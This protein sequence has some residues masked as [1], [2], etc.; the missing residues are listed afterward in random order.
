MN[1]KRDQLYDNL[2]GSGKVGEAEIGNREEFK[3]AISDEAKTRQFYN[4]IINSGL[5]SEDEIGNEDEFYNSI[6]G[7]FSSAAGPGSTKQPM[8]DAMAK[9]NA[10]GYKPT[11]ED[12]AAFQSTINGANKTVSGSLQSFDKKA[13]NLKKRQ[14]LNVPKEVK[15]G[16]GNNLVEGEQHLNPE[17][18]QLEKTYITASGN[19]YGNKMLA[20]EEQRQIDQSIRDEKY[21]ESLPG[22]IDDAEAEGERLDA[23]IAKLREG[24]H[25][26][27]M[28]AMYGG[29]TDKDADTDRRLSTL[30]AAKRK[31]D[32][33][34]K[35]L[36]A[37]RDDDGGTQ[38]WRGFYDAIT[39][40]DVYS[41][42]V[43][44]LS[45]A[46]QM[47]KLKN[48]IDNAREQGV[49]PEFTDE[50]KTL[51]QSIENSERAQQI[52]G[53][54]RGSMYNFGSGFAQSLPF[55]FEI[56]ATGGMSGLSNVGF[57]AGKK[58]ATKIATAAVEKA[59]IRNLGKGGKWIAD[60]AVKGSGA[61][62]GIT[63]GG[64]IMANTT[65]A[66][67]T[68]ADIIDRFVGNMTRDENG[69]LQFEDGVSVGEAIAKG[70]LAQAFEYG[71]ELVGDKYIEKYMPIIGEAAMRTIRK[72]GP[73]KA[74]PF[75]EALLT[76][77]LTQ[78]IGKLTKSRYF[79]KGEKALNYAG[80][81][82]WFA[83]GMEEEAN[84]ILNAI[85][86]GDVTWNKTDANKSAVFDTK[87]QLELWE[88]T[89]LTSAL[90][91]A[92]QTIQ[93]TGKAAGYYGYKHATDAA[94][95]NAASIF[96][97]NNWQMIKEEIDKCTNE[98][99][100]SL[101]ET[102]IKGGMT[103][104]QKE[105]TMYYADNLLK[106][107]GYNAALA[108]DGFGKKDD[109]DELID[110][111]LEKGYQQGHQ[112]EMPDDQKAVVD[113]AKKAEENLRQYG[114][115]FAIL[116]TSG[117]DHPGNTLRY[118]MEH[119]DDFTDEQIAAAT[120]YY[121]KQ[122]ASDAMMDAAIDD[123]DLKIRQNTANI[124]SNSHTDSNQVITAVNGDNTYY[125]IGGEVATDEETGLP[126]IIGTGGAV[127]VKD[128]QTGEISVMAPQQLMPVSAVN[129][130][131]LVAQSEQ[132]LNQQLTQQVE[133]NIDYGSP[134]NEVFQ[135]GDL[136]TL[137]DREGNTI[138]GQISQLPNTMDG[139]FQ[140]TTSDNKNH[141]YTLDELNLMIVSHNGQQ[142]QR[143]N[144]GNEQILAESEQNQADLEQNPTQ[145]AQNAGNYSQNQPQN[146][147]EVSDNTLG[148]NE[149]T[150][151]E[152]AVTPEESPQ[153]AAARIPLNEKGEPDYLHAQPQDSYDALVE[154]LGEE[155]A[156]TIIESE[157]GDAQKR[158]ARLQKKAPQG[159]TIEEKKRSLSER[160]AAMEAEQSAIDYW[161]SVLE[162]PKTRKAEAERKAEEERRRAEE[163]RRAMMQTPD[164]RQQLLSEARN[165]QE[166]TQVAKEIYGEYFNENIGEPDTAEELV[167]LLLPYGKLNWEGYQR[168]TSHV[169][170]LQEELGSGHTR[171]LSKSR[172]TS[173]FNSYLARKGEGESL[174][175]IV[176]Q[177]YTSDANI[178][179][180]E[181]RFS[182]EEIKDAAI[183]MLLE[184]EKPT[185]I[186]DY[187]I[188]SRIDAAERTLRAE[189]EAEA[190]EWA[191][192]Y[193]LTSEEREQF[194]A[195]LEMPP[196]EPEIEVINQI[197]AEY[198]QDTNGEGV[199]RGNTDESTV[200]ESEGSKVDVPGQS[201][202]EE[203][204][205]N[206]EQQ[207]AGRTE[208][209]SEGETLPGNDVA[210]GT[211]KLQPVGIGDFG[212]I[213]DQFKGKAKEAI[214][215]LI[216]KKEGEAIG[217]L[218]HKDVGEIDLV[219]GEEGTG[220]SDGYGL[221]KLV[222][223][224]PE[225]LDNLQGILDEMTVTSRTDNRVNLES[226]KYKAAVRLTWNEES[227]T[228]LLTVFEKKPSATDKTTDT[229]GNQNDSRSDTA[230][231]R[232]E[233]ISEGKDTNNIP[234]N[235]ENLGK[236]SS[237][238]VIA[239]EEAKVD[240]NP[241]EA[242]KEAGNYQMG[243][244]K[245]DGMD[246]SIENPKGSV[247]RGTD[248]NGHQWEQEMHNSYGYIRG[249]EAV[250]GDHIDVFLSDDPASGKV[251]VVDQVNPETGEF[252]EP[253]VMLGF[254]DA[255]E[256][257]KA[258]LSNYEE[259]WKGLGN[260]TGVSREAFKEWIESSH[261]KT[262]PF[263]DYAL[264][265]REQARQAK[266]NIL[267]ALGELQDN[268]KQY[269]DNKPEAYELGV[270]FAMTL[271]KGTTSKEALQL[272]S[273]ALDA[274]KAKGGL[275]ALPFFDGV[276]ETIK[277]KPDEGD[278]T[279]NSAE[280][281]SN[282]INEGA[283]SEDND[284][285]L[286]K[287]WESLPTNDIENEK[288]G[289]H[290]KGLK[291][292]LDENYKE[293]IKALTGNGS[294]I[295][296]SISLKRARTALRR[297]LDGRE[298]RYREWQEKYNIDKEGRIS[299]EDLSRLFHDHNQS[300]I[301]GK[302]FEKV[303][304][305]A[306]PL[307]LDIFFDDNLDAGGASNYNGRVRY[308][309]GLLTSSGYNWQDICRTILHELIHSVTQST[310][311]AYKRGGEYA[312]NLTEGQRKAA[313][314]IID[315]FGE[316]KKWADNNG[317]GETYGFRTPHEM[318]AEMASLNFRDILKAI[319]TKERKSIW[320]ILKDAMHGIFSLTK[321]ADA[322]KR[323][324]K[325]LD[326]L[327]ENF[328]MDTYEAMRGYE[329]VENWSQPKETERTLMGVHNI[330]EEKLKKAL[331]QGGLANPSMA[332][333]DTKNY[334]HTDYGE[335]SLIPRSS[336]IDSRTGR[337]AGT[338]SGDAWTPT[339][340]NVER[341]L[342]KK[343][344]KHRLQIAKD[345]ADGD[346][347]M[348]RHLAGVIND[349]VEGNG[350]RMHFLFLKQKGLNPEVRPERTTH[351]H[352]E[353]EEIQ[354]IF[355]E[356]TSTLPSNGITKEQN[357]ALL[358]LMTKGYEEQ[359]RKQAEMIKDE[360]KREAAAKL[361]LERKLNDLVDEN[362][363]VWFAKGD[364]FVYENWRDEQRRKNPKPDW[365]GTD[366]DASYRVAKEG[367][368]EEYEKWKEDLL[369]DE[370]IDEKLFAGWTADGRKRYVA[371]TVQNASRLMNKE[372]DTNSYGNGGVNASK[373]GLLKKLK[374]LSDIRKY[375]HLL[376]SEDQIKEQAQQ[377]S[378]EWFDII[379]QVSDMQKVDSNPFINVDIAEA[380]L[381]EA[382]T[383]R[384]PIGYLN[385][386]YRYSI[387]R[388]SDLVSD[389][390][391]FIEKAKEMPVKYFETKFKRP[392]GIDEFAIAVVPTTTS[393]EVIEALK[394][395]GLDV[396]TYERGSIGDA[397][398]EAR[399]KAT[400]DAVKE[401][402]DILFQKA[403]AAPGTPA[404][405]ER[406]LRDA[407][408][409]HL[410]SA[411]ID[412]VTDLEEGQR[413][414]LEKR[415]VK[416]S[417]KPAG[418]V[419]EDINGNPIRQHKVYHGSGAEFDAFDHSHMGEGE[420]YQTFGYGTYVTDVSD[421]AEGY[422]EKGARKKYNR[423]NQGYGGKEVLYKGKKIDLQTV[424]PLKM[425]YDM[426]N[427]EG[428]VNKAIRTSE[429]LKGYA[430]DPEMQQKWQDVIDI[431]KDS[432][433]S[434]F[435]AR[436]ADLSGQRYV[437]EVEI[438]DDNGEN[439]LDYDSKPTEK[440]LHNIVGK[441]LE[442]GLTEDPVKEM[443]IAERLRNAETIGNII[444]ILHQN[445]GG[446]STAK[447]LHDAGY[448][449]TKYST[450][451]MAG[452]NRKGKKNYV[453]Y[454]ESDAKITDVTKFFRTSDG[455]A[456]GYT[457]NGK[458]YI[459]PS[460]ATAETPVHEYT[461]LWAEAVRQNDPKT[462][463][464]IV[465]VLKKD[466]AVR[467]FWNKVAA[468][469][470]E[471]T[472]DNDIAEE[473]LAQYS[474][475]RGSEKLR[476]EADDIAKENGGIFGKAQAVEAL[477][478]MRNILN[479]F[480]KA[481]SDMMGWQYTR[482]EEVAD[483]V[484]SDL[485]NGVKPETEGRTTV[486]EQRVDKQRP[487]LNTPSQEVNEYNKRLE[488]PDD[489]SWAKA[490]YMVPV[491]RT[492]R[493]YVGGLFR[494]AWQDSMITLKRGQ[495][496]IVRASGKPLQ[497][498]EDA[499]TLENLS[500]GIAKNEYEWF[501]DNLYKP[502]L[503]SFL[504]LKKAMNATDEAVHRYMFAKHGL[505][506]NVVMAF[507]DAVKR[508]VQAAERDY[509]TRKKAYDDAE[510]RIRQ[511]E[512]NV[513]DL[514]RLGFSD[515]AEERRKELNRAKAAL[516]RRKVPDKPQ[517]E[518][519]IHKAYQADEGRIQN[520]K[521]FNE[522]RIDYRTY[523]ERD[524]QIRSSYAPESYLILRTNDYS[525]LTGMFAETKD[526]NGVE[527]TEKPNT[528]DAEDM[529][530]KMVDTIEKAHGPLT[531]DLWQKVNGC[532]KWTLL[533]SY[534]GGLLSRE[535]HDVIS[536]MYDFY[537]PL[538]GWD[539]TNAQDVYDYVG[540]RSGVFS[541]SVIPAKGRTS[542]ADNPIAYIGNMAM[543][544][545]II[546]QKNMVKQRV[547]N[548]ARNHPN[549]LL[550][551]D[552]AWYVN[553]GDDANPDWTAVSPD[554]P[555]NATREEIVDIID[556]F[557]KRMRELKAEGKATQ[558][559]GSLSISYPAPDPQ[560]KEHEI[561]LMDNGEEYIIYVN[562]DPRVAQAVNGTRA[563]K[564]RQGN[565]GLITKMAE[566]SGRFKAA[567]YTSFSPAFVITN[568]TRDISM[569]IT[570]SLIDKGIGYNAKAAKNTVNLLNP[571]NKNNICRMMYLYKHDR[572]DMQSPTQRMFKEFM[573]NG[574]ETGFIAQLDLE[575]FKN[576]INKELGRA[577]QG[578][579]DPRRAF[580]VYLEWTE[581]LNRCIEDSTRFIVYKTSRQSGETA[582]KSAS[583][584]K[585]VTLNFNRKG[586]GEL[587][588]A[589]V[590]GAYIFVNPAVQGIQTVFRL[591]KN[592]P[593]KF[594]AL[595]TSWIMGGAM[596][597]YLNQMLMQ[598]LG[599]GD[600]GDEDAY[601][602][603]PEHVRRQ[604]L[605]FY[606]G[607]GEFVTIPLAQEF[608]AFWGI[609]ET[610]SARLMGHGKGDYVDDGMEI[611]ESFIDLLPL[612]LLGHGVRDA[613]FGSREWFS[614]MG[615]NLTPDIIKTEVE[616]VANKDWTG[617]P[618]FKETQ[619]NQELPAWSKAYKGTP[620]YLVKSTELLN[621][622]T[623][624]EGSW[625]PGK[626]DWN[627]A[628][629][630]HEL[631]GWLSG[632]FNFFG[633]IGDVSYKVL[634]GEHV[635][636]YDVPVLN[637]ILNA[638]AERDFNSNLGDEY[639]KMYRE[640]YRPMD[641]S[642]SQM[643]REA[644]EGNAK[645][646]K[647]V[648]DFF[649]SDDY[650][651]YKE[652]KA[653]VDLVDKRKKAEAAGDGAF[654]FEYTNER[655]EKTPEEQYK[656]RLD[657]KDEFE[658]WCVDQI[659]TKT[660]KYAT[661]LENMR[662]N[663]AT[664]QEQEEYRDRFRLYIEAR[665]AVDRYR[666]FRNNRRQPLGRANEDSEKKIMQEIRAK[667]DEL[668]RIYRFD[669]IFKK[670]TEK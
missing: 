474:G 200:A 377:A 437:Y 301:L 485:L 96:G 281:Y 454:D 97:E 71:S 16:E 515:R 552:K 27:L 399:I 441:F 117:N 73:E 382:M 289:W 570:S 371:N 451:Y 129:A 369:G 164:G 217:A 606:V 601:W 261:R 277:R 661:E 240:T 287:G 384:D 548:L 627:P 590:R 495:D 346:A 204:G 670:E 30:L 550:T 388:N 101:L 567:V 17:T 560:L 322:E 197:I 401:R 32:E 79:E 161:N 513:D 90:L 233:G 42:G 280:N 592:H 372:A 642:F 655:R 442:S 472:D 214:D 23:E 666:D 222:K 421:V 243:H 602:K 333:F 203:A 52:F 232:T 55:M 88:Q 184:A 260:I 651:R 228:W 518:A 403:E 423:L 537:I 534:Q 29:R 313:Q 542:V 575:S 581:F 366:N 94:D 225:V 213:Y 459:D 516:E 419:T 300:K 431:L 484:L 544:N 326:D 557:N 188:N 353:F 565:G 307:N 644:R 497:D 66:A 312:A 444:D 224:H 57:A 36:K 469:Y 591:I 208:V 634:N 646:L 128:A 531:E 258:Y 668:L 74:K 623:G 525:G 393:P 325:A 223:Y 645:A 640:E 610:V 658:E 207:S 528:R 63:G 440:Q 249:T 540:G 517:T 302:L 323:V 450:N 365:Y 499:Y 114:E 386:E 520:E 349:Y 245:V 141:P 334:A 439:Y 152:T 91:R 355:G 153:S 361:M 272:A 455:Q 62:G 122:T 344:D 227:K 236:T 212:P 165:S 482:A 491:N 54:N 489:F 135:S 420:G 283:E 298:R 481:V 543:S 103:Q 191:D 116:V 436:M 337:N 657:G 85:F 255:A 554:I 359:V 137:R 533:K 160:R 427:N 144:Q 256:A 118:L 561:R 285:S 327:V 274:N 637:R 457:Y 22:Q 486:M 511:M 180:D 506:R 64:L 598:A 126:Q 110:D 284:V 663:G 566:K 585:D 210:G 425:A 181:H 39:N 620:S 509:E 296:G 380:R 611:M 107:R 551:P 562:G 132:E 329:G 648:E 310:V 221:A 470:P 479:K 343:G 175:D 31:N 345:A 140:V 67:K 28:D 416:I 443:R 433:K 119:R 3:A 529:A 75:L 92:P 522:G 503:S 612:D 317:Y 586:T 40:P 571:F 396:R 81:Q 626:L 226:D 84:N 113:E 145:N 238:E 278:E 665:E 146:I 582:Q 342:T 196:T 295:D 466:P 46:T 527:V 559:R 456:Y 649:M 635:N 659:G 166:R 600:D 282:I 478:K 432:K 33:R 59:M 136:V 315:I 632:P 202:A 56:A 242:Q 250:D 558:T 20:D 629:I 18:G 266:E 112:A 383:K 99:L 572:L 418:S 290:I 448:V 311:S 61:L 142:V 12:M 5:L 619:N 589:F 453:I 253:K 45:D 309:T 364:T 170:G 400:M 265:K 477:R 189:L 615:L 391:N 426:I 252:D 105:A 269:E 124:R 458:I 288:Q 512:K 77:K 41:F 82:G 279:I 193:H 44:G 328:N 186:R 480:W 157:I 324:I 201:A 246:I 259:G 348:E 174:D 299:L 507:R 462:W 498:Y 357:Q 2:I 14:G 38:F 123:I 320:E 205:A 538:R 263:R 597:P 476:E 504:A 616:S 603:L 86:V 251:F 378:D 356:G 351:S 604:C 609:G 461:H 134:A 464:N 429:R 536:G 370:D 569:A 314:Q 584:A 182:T 190:D 198:E 662:K 93:T 385:K 452:G 347:E 247:R 523:R 406:T 230:L 656:E 650:K 488:K 556:A 468:Q 505:E 102:V 404:Q 367:L 319:K 434:D 231:P 643:K 69:N 21:R 447:L 652:M 262:K 34:L 574:G 350:D 163:N 276:T 183:S 593:Y 549:Q 237:P 608:R 48:K 178:S 248:Q 172:G 83:E 37:E 583:E 125:V 138:E 577:G 308:N 502:L 375:R 669:D 159:A 631:Q 147:P 268:G 318:L 415:G 316:L 519:E 510:R 47:L 127:T 154:D 4:N 98:D 368:A 363:N 11:A 438:P 43:T 408:V 654:D 168:G 270:Q 541:K 156:N 286:P 379:H 449:G 521:D 148:E 607:G 460:I 501:D 304:E 293:L 578:K 397:N 390:M 49:E 26:R 596:Q 219:W 106:M 471:L 547:L 605:V 463:D 1:D 78:G 58:A 50:E 19:E 492:W 254:D 508:H 305:V 473:V 271:P 465:D 100:P 446:E 653:Q 354:K 13:Q 341:F 15:V 273:E 111:L 80:V 638:P 139:T 573:M 381:Q 187:T 360:S 374:T 494:E 339:Y 430:E 195:Y 487:D 89:V 133:N 95:A 51:I 647:A 358:D 330:S 179:G 424:N 409:D 411:G 220:H 7:D 149:N 545:I 9:E 10:G 158:L 398:D 395:A 244:I 639:W 76:N 493:K 373:A 131:D 216:E 173:G 264:A 539:G 336:L 332:V 392:V 24:A 490:L 413:A 564:I 199:D 294:G 412:V 660:A 514:E 60:M 108:A 185:D 235:Q 617:K 664:P 352:E 143:G 555:E 267:N 6:S 241:S 622:A 121:Q 109:V 530:M 87:D 53:R 546:A 68:S 633:G 321:E 8:L 641:Q 218:S 215:F 335:I 171:G 162:I 535:M 25:G 667:R 303:A 387:D 475:K 405:N 192:A 568:W 579:V 35:I 580:R 428:T 435:K 624:G 362:G 257:V 340:P 275:Y 563:R 72:L 394:N 553:M 177:M 414:E 65:G 211:Q 445:I 588:N 120:D 524:D 150:P 625:K 169:R 292:L 532:T 621:E 483:K 422:A 618:L 167:S 599:P 417:S 389:L 630:N 234:N 239:A 467:P 614:A 194:E 628:I 229:V 376:K 576:N 209:G 151:E 500:H 587:G 70:Q 594:T 115:E 526:V 410:K 613:E 306:K 496:A 331:K 130:D 155:D 176:H 402:D 338:Y 206:N 291:T 407:L 595:T 636:V 297:E 104:K